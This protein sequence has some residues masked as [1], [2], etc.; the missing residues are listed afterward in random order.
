M[1]V[2]PNDESET[3]RNTYLGLH[4]SKYNQLATVANIEKF[5]QGPKYETMQTSK[6]VLNINNGEVL[7]LTNDN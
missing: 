3:E 2:C 5:V 7:I 6:E 4:Y 1:Q